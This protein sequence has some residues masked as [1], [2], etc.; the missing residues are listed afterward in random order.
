MQRKMFDQDLEVIGTNG[1]TDARFFAANGTKTI[2]Y[3][4]GDDQS[5]P[6]GADESVAVN[7]IYQTAGVIAATIIDYTH[8]R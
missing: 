2:K 8:E 7:Q 4:P 5:N 3:G 1:F 6:P